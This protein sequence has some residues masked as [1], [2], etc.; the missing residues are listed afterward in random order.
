MKLAVLVCSLALFAIGALLWAG[1][2]ASPVNLQHA[3]ECRDLVNH[4]LDTFEAK[5]EGLAEAELRDKDLVDVVALL[6]KHGCLTEDQAREILTY[7][8]HAAPGDQLYVVHDGTSMFHVTSLSLE[9]REK[10]MAL[11]S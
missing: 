3:T 5:S 8:R 7:N 9:N 10:S 2:T 6:M 11:S 1:L 4:G